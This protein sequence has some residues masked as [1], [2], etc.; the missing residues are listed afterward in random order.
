MN[1]NDTATASQPT[2]YVEHPAR[3]RAWR[4]AQRNLAWGTAF[5]FAALSIVSVAAFIGGPR[6]LLP[7]FIGV[8]SFTALWV[9]ARMKI[10]AQRNGVFFSLAIIALLGAL[11]ALIEQGWLRFTARNAAEP[12][13]ATS[14]STPVPPPIPSLIDALA[15]EPPDASLP[16]A[17]AVR[18]VTTTIG[19]RTYRIRPGDVFLFADEKN[20]EFTLSAGEFLA[21]VPADA[22]E[23]LAPAPAKNTAE[24]PNDVESVL[25]QKANAEITQRAQAEAMRRYP[26]LGKAGT[27][28]NKDFVDTVKDLTSRKSDFLNN[29]EWPLE[30]AQ[31]LARRNG[32]KEAGVIDDTAPPVVEPSLAPGTK[33]L[34]EPITPGPAIDPDIPPPPREPGR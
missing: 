10:F 2:R 12:R 8:L 17:R 22:M 21:R 13:V 31:M 18:E 16:R 27:P 6:A 9:L 14:V 3:R 28:E 24:K 32:W 25:D 33:M 4:A 15:L 23:M 34:A 19:S 20:G 1:P 30:L 26:A 7:L 11:A 5:I 29:P